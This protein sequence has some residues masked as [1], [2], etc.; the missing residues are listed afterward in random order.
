MAVGPIDWGAHD[1]DLVERALA[2]ML[3][4]QRPHAW[5]RIASRGDAGVDVADPQQDGYEVFQIKS[6]TGSLTA[7]RQNQIR[8]SFEGVLA[9]GELDRPVV[10]W[11]LLLPMGP[12]KEME[13][14]FRELT[15]DAPFECEW[16]GASRVDLLAATNPHV[17]DYY[18][19][20][21]KARVEQRYRD[22]LQ[23]RALIESAG[24]G[25]RPAEV[26]ESLREL[27]EALNR[28]DPHYRY[29]C[30]A[31]PDAPPT[32]TEGA[33][34]ELVM[35]A[36]E[37]DGDRGC[38]TIRVFA[39]HR[40]AVE[41]RPIRIRF[42]VDAAG[43]GPLQ[44]ALDFGSTAELHDGVV[45]DLVVDAPGGLDTACGS[46]ALR[47]SG[48]VEEDFIP[49]RLRLA[50]RNPEGAEQACTT[51]AVVERRAGNRGKT[52]IC[53]EVGGAFTFELRITDPGV[54]DA[55]ATL[56]A[57]KVTAWGRAPKQ[58]QA[59]VGLLA[60]MS[61]PNELDVSLDSFGGEQL[62]VMSLDEAGPIVPVEVAEFVDD[63][64]ELQPHCS[65]PLMVP[66]S[67]THRDVRRARQAARLVRGTIIDGTWA[68]GHLTIDPEY[69][70]EHVTTL[71]E[72]HA[73]ALVLPYETEVAGQVI[74]LGDHLVRFASVRVADSASVLSGGTTAPAGKDGVTVR[75][76]PGDDDS[77]ERLWPAPTHE[78]EPE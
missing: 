55:T 60:A 19:R 3:L 51:V 16:L 48:H 17:V 22:L 35:S 59:G 58:V 36:T 52:L 13:A 25:P 37:C 20:D 1:G 14:W 62:M 76:V 30:E 9:G 33:R 11:R 21:G 53:K 43:S 39:R 34:P 42:G 54:P 4:Q 28:D 15:K 64:A 10:A 75:I 57:W 29:A 31:S 73:M 67:I 32:W 71:A 6:F 45:R 23:A 24:A 38:I 56:A 2:V 12:T 69:V 77:L 27:L 40:H 61:A 72:P 50:V 66:D 65:A 47:V 70:T 18:F 44:T 46:A 41:D 49:F 5:R 68:E 7:A 8:K 74:S 78:L 26:K 63:L